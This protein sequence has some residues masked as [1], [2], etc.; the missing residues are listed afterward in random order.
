LTPESISESSVK[1]TETGG[2]VE[3]VS[4]KEGL[5]AAEAENDGEKL[6]KPSVEELE[7]TSY[8]HGS[9]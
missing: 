1:I 8:S 2:N 5:M 3:I 6:L 9:D 4:P 7:G